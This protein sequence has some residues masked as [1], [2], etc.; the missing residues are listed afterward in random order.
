VTY[1]LSLHDALPIFASTGAV[2]E[3]MN[4]KA[5]MHACGSS[6]LSLV[7]LDRS[8]ASSYCPGLVSRGTTLTHFTGAPSGMILAPLLTALGSRSEEH[9]SELQS[10][11]E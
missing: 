4:L 3:W 9:T 8:V 1:T 11:S 5:R 10:R 6:W 2:P 7:A